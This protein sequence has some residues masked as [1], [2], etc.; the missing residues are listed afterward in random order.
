MP[1]QQVARRAIYPKKNSPENKASEL[2]K[3]LGRGGRI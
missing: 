1:A 3:V 2:L